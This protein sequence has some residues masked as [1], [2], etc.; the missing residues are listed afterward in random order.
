[1]ESNPAAS[2][3]YMRMGELCQYLGGL[4]PQTVRRLVKKGELPQPRKINGRSVPFW[5]SDEIDARMTECGAEPAKVSPNL[6]PGRG[7][8]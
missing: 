6:I 4:T 2:H 5:R 3:R 7:Q 1:M 8:S